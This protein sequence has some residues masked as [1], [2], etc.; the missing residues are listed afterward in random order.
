MKIYLFNV[1]NADKWLNGIDAK[2]QVKEVG[3]LV[4]KE[5][6]T[7]NNITFDR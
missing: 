3:P 1:T 7:K 4:Y 6:W 2:L 5:F